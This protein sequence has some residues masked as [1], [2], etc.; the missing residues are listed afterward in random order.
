VLQLQLDI[1]NICANRLVLQTLGAD[2][3]GAECC[4]VTNGSSILSIGVC[5]VVSVR[6]YIVNALFAI[7][8]GIDEVFIRPQA[9]NHLHGCFRHLAGAGNAKVNVNGSGIKVEIVQNFALQVV[10]GG[11][12]Q[13]CTGRIAAVSVNG[14]EAAARAEEL[15]SGAGSSCGICLQVT[16]LVPFPHQFALFHKGIGCIQVGHGG[17]TVHAN[18]SV[19][20]G[21]IQA[22]NF[23]FGAQDGTDQ[24]GVA[25]IIGCIADDVGVICVDLFKYCFQIFNTVH[26]AHIHTGGLGNVIIPDQVAVQGHALVSRHRV[27]RAVNGGSGVRVFVKILFQLGGHFLT[28]FFQQVVH[29]SQHVGS[30]VVCQRALKECIDLIAALHGQLNF[31]GVLCRSKQLDVNGDVIVRV[32]LCQVIIHQVLN[33]GHFTVFRDVIE[34]HAVDRNVGRL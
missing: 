4:G 3:A 14:G 9:V 31:L 34:R 17:I 16:L 1:G 5:P 15:R 10:T 20:V 19:I 33:A 8:E 6:L 29:R 7:Q 24:A 2:N 23:F 18:T 13:H 21:V 32:G 12:A 11:Q 25:L 27:N 26:R 30:H 22:V 28:V